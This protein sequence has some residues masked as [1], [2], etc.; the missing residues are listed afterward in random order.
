M[1]RKHIEC[2][3]VK[4]PILAND[5]QRALTQLN[6]EY[7]FDVFEYKSEYGII[8]RTE[9]HVFMSACL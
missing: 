2:I 7:T 4:D 5:I 8:E 6:P 1:Q 3:T 9:I